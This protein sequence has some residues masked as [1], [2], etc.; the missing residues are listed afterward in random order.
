[1]GLFTLHYV[2]KNGKLL[3][4]NAKDENGKPIANDGKGIWEFKHRWVAV[5]LLAIIMPPMLILAGICRFVKL[6]CVKIKD[7]IIGF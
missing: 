5:I 2:D 4:L 3:D 7:R 6:I 1:M